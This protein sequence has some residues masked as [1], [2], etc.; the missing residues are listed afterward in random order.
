MKPVPSSGETVISNNGEFR[1]NRVDSEHGDHILEMKLKHKD[2]EWRIGY[3]FN[4]KNPTNDIS[5]F[6]EI[7]RII[8]EHQESPFNKSP[9]ITRLTDGGNI[10]LTNTSYTEWKDGVVTKE[11]ID[12]ARFRMLLGQ[13]FGIPIT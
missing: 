9:L 7:Q 12:Y 13:R 4:S 8:A 5:E 11:Q 2:T 1:I 3:A 10:S 6:N